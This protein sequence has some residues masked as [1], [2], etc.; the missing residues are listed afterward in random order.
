MVVI[1]KAKYKSG[2][3]FDVECD[4][5]D[6]DSDNDFVLIYKDGKVVSKLSK[7]RLEGY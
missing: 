5:Y 1:Y 4:R 2:K 6:K 7:K 3:S